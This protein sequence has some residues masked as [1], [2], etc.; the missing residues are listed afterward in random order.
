MQWESVLQKTAQIELVA[1]QTAQW[2]EVWRADVSPIW[3]LQTSGISVVHHQDPQGYWLPE[4]RP[5]AGEKVLLTI[6]RPVAIEGRTLTIDSSRM[7]LTPGKRSQ[8][9]S[10]ELSIRSS[11]GTQHAITLPKNATLQSVLIDGVTQPIRQK[12]N[13]VTLPI[14]PGTQHI[15]INWLQMQSQN[16][17]LQTPPVNLGV[18]SVNS[19]LNVKLGED[20][21][22]MLTAGPRFGPA[23]LFW[24]VLIVIACVAVGL[25]KIPFTPLKHWQWFLLLVGLSQIEL[26]AALI[27]VAWL[28]AL[29][30]RLNK[31]AIEGKYFNA[32]QVGLAVLTLLSLSLLF[33]AV[34]HG[35][36]NSP[37]M[38]IVG[39]QS[40]AFNLN[41]YQDRSAA[42][43]PT[44]TVVMLPLMA[45]RVLMLLW[46]LWLAASLL[47]WLKWGWGCFSSG[48]LWKKLPLKKKSLLVEEAAKQS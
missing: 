15:T 30:L 16:G 33:T 6:T 40:S 24:G 28:I 31:S 32:M 18:D 27:V 9:V 47:S 46:S 19:H 26:V 48:G 29:G 10:L 20:R 34:Q 4:W 17:V 7:Q 44:A 3:H 12:G 42:Q 41:W 14:K 39:N 13:T 11:K 1:A 38:Q 21:W 25:G 35:L 2:T 45:Y 5:W 23:V 37:D 43:L 8:E 22:V 36:L